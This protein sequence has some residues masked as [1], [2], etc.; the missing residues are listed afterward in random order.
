M[1]EY[2][3]LLEQGFG[4]GATQGSILHSVPVA[5]GIAWLVFLLKVAIAFWARPQ[6]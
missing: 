4:L 2:S 6:G 1:V 3:A 5:I